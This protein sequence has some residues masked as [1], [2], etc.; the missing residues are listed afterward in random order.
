[1]PAAN[2]PSPYRPKYKFPNL[3]PKPLSWADAA[4][5]F[6]E[7]FEQELAEKAWAA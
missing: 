4:D 7:T 1:M 2:G 5:L 3:R 6:R